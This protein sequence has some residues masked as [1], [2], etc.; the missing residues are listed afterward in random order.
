MVLRFCATPMEKFLMVTGSFLAVLQSRTSHSMVLVALILGISICRAQAADDATI[1]VTAVTARMETM[2]RVING[3]GTVEPLQSVIV[4]PRI[5]GQVVEIPF[6]EGHPGSSF[7][8]LLIRNTSPHTTLVVR[9]HRSGSSSP[10]MQAYGGNELHAASN[11]KFEGVMEAI[12]FCI[13]AL[14]NSCLRTA[15]YLGSMPIA[16]ARDGF[17]PV[18]SYQ[19]FPSGGF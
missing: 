6:T 17:L 15:Q 12:S 9:P 16:D 11:R 7:K 1:P 4:R 13:G 2:H 14:H 3:I 19:L 18:P 5:E 8:D 10:L